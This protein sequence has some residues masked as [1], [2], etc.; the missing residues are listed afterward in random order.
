MIITVN[1]KAIEDTRNKI[2]EYVSNVFGGD[3]LI[4]E[5]LLYNLVS[6]MYILILI[7]FLNS[8]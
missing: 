3:E 7:I 6:R 4:A 2:V 1:D 8:K 5:Y